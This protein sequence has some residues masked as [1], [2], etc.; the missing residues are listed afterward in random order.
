MQPVEAES[1]GLPFA[2]SVIRVERTE[3]LTKPGSQPTTGV[4][5]YVSSLPCPE[6]CR[7]PKL[8]MKAAQKFARVSRSHW[9]IE[10]KNHWKKDAQWGDDKPRQKS[11]TVARSLSLLKGGLLAMIREPLPLL[12]KRCAKFN[13]LAFGIVKSALK[14]LN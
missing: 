9:S 1:I 4:R 6:P 5:T 7:E 8:A 13:H 10:N 11:P 3:T 12:F 14:P 2:Q